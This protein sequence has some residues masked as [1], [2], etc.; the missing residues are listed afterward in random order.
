MLDKSTYGYRF[1]SGTTINHLLYMD[2]IKLYAKNEQDIDSL[3][4]LT[5]MSSYDT[6]I[7]L[8]LAK[9]RRLI[10]NKNKVKST[11]GISLLEG[12]IDDIDKSYNYLGILQPFVNND[13]DVC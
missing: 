7:T 4:H 11:C 9:C 8:G 5:P 1:K 3:I 6:K 13:E 12:Q 10:V 2:N